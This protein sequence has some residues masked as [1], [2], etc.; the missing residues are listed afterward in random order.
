MRNRLLLG[1]ACGFALAC[2]KEE[3]HDA[4]AVTPS[5]REAPD[6]VGVIPDPK[7]TKGSTVDSLTAT[8][9]QV[10]A[11]LTAKDS[12]IKEIQQ[13]HVS[14]WD[15]PINVAARKELETRLRAILGPV[16]GVAGPGELNATWLYREGTEGGELDALRFGTHATDTIVLATHRQLVA[17][18]AR[19]EGDTSADPYIGLSHTLTWVL[20]NNAHA[21]I[22]TDI[23]SHAK[24]PGDVAVALLLT[25]AQ[26]VVG[27]EPPQTLVVG[28]RRDPAFTL[29]FAPAAGVPSPP[30]CVTA[31]ARAREASQRFFEEEEKVFLDC[32]DR[33]A[34]RQPDFQHYVEQVV[35]IA[36]MYRG[37]GRP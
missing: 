9:G 35:T 37:G 18:W 3:T 34:P 32:F 1:I 10:A 33:V 21:T 30:E 28:V 19:A 16:P 14:G 25:Y 12:L 6:F 36:R 24:L 2:Q 22:F 7:L 11:Y 29:V 8:Q 15:N 5:G 27:P 20:G 23:K 13:R 31:L 26:D 4:V 17:A